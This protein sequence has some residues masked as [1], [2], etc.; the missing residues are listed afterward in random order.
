[1]NAPNAPQKGTATAP[2]VLPDLPYAFDALAPV[3]SPLVLELHHDKHHA[4]YVKGANETLARLQEAEAWQTPGLEQSLAFNVG[5]HLLHSLFWTC[6][7][8]TEQRPQGQLEAAIAEQYGSFESFRKQFTQVLTTV[9]GSGWAVLSWESMAQRLVIQQIHD[10]HGSHVVSAHPILVADAWEHAY[11]LDHHT[12][13][14]KWADAFFTLAN[15]QQAGA[16]FS[17]IYESQ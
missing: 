14:D 2:Y 8:P 5:G 15:W 6:L 10:H 11:Y 9:Q 12:A 1:M 17:A 7:S 4:A 16:R 13:K 3:M